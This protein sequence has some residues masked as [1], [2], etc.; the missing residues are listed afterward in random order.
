[1]LIFG[2]QV[3]VRMKFKRLG[4]TEVEERAVLANVACFENDWNAVRALPR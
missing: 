2:P 4:S 1:M 3:T